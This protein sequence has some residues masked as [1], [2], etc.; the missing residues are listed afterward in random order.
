MREPAEIED[1]TAAG[2]RTALRRA[3]MRYRALQRV[4]Q[5]IWQMRDPD[6]IDQ[7]WQAIVDSLRELEIPFDHC[8]I[9]V[10]REPGTESAA[11][12]R[13]RT[14]AGLGI[15]E[16]FWHAGD[17]V[18]RHNLE[19]KDVYQERTRIEEQFGRTVRAVIDVPFSHGTL[20]LN[21]ARIDPFSPWH[22]EV[23]EDFTRALSGGFRRIEDLVQLEERNRELEREVSEG[24][25]Q[26]KRQQALHRVR[27]QVWRMR[28]SEEIADV[29]EKVGDGLR[30]MEV[31]FVFCGVNVVDTG[32]QHRASVYSMNKVGEWTQRKT[33]GT[34]SIL[35]IW[36]AG[37]IAYRRDI[38]QNDPYGERAR[39]HT[40]RSLLDV[41]FS[42]GTLAISSRCPGAFSD[43]DVAILQELAAALSE[44]FRRMDDLGTL[45]ERNRTLEQEVAEKERREQLQTARYRVREQVW[46]MRRTEDIAAVLEAVRENF[47]I[48]GVTY[49]YCSISL[50]QEE[51][52]E[53]QVVVYTLKKEGEWKR[54]Q[55]PFSEELPFIQIWRQNRLVYR[56]DI[57][58]D[59]PYDEGPTFKIP[60]RALVDVPFTQG[61]LALSS[62]E[63]DVFSHGDLE[64]LQVTAQLLAE[65][66]QRMGDLEVLEERNRDLEQEVTERRQTEQE[67]V[68]AKEE[69]E[70]ANRTKSTFLAHMS[71]E[72]R[73]P[74]NAILGFAQLLQRSP[75]LSPQQLENLQTISRSGEHLLAL[76]N[77]VLEMSRIEA[78][79]TLLEEEV[80]DLHALL[81]GL[82]EMFGLRAR[83]KGLQ[84]LCERGEDLPRY[85]RADEGKLRQILI[86][87]LSNAIK[88]TAGGGVVIRVKQAADRLHFEVEDTGLGI[89]PEEQKTLFDA[90][91]QTDTGKHMQAG[92]GLGLAITQQFV[93]LMGGEIEVKSAVGKGS[94]FRFDLP[95]CPAS[96]EELPHS[97]QTRRAVALEPGQPEYRILVVEDQE[98]NRQLMRQL[99]EPM[100][101]AFKEATDGRQGVDL[102][103]KWK[104]HLIWM[105]MRMPV[106]D[107]YE[108]T[109]Q[110]KAT[111]QGEKTK[112][113]ALTASAFEED[114]QKVLEAGC[115]DF[116]RKPFR[117]EEIFA[118]LE[119]HLGIRFLYEDEEE[120]S[121]T[122]ETLTSD[123]L[124]ELSQELVTE[125]YRVASQADDEGL[126]RLLEQIEIE[127]ENIARCLAEL[128]RNFRFDEIMALAARGSE[129]IEAS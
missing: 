51:L 58:R 9:N 75:G 99:L 24:E 50:V 45:E 83:D 108:A 95:A 43:E 72:L 127:H 79:R 78:G 97:R 54:Y 21:S 16:N 110:I 115:D 3:E 86:N 104:P 15:V 93:R 28:R 116:V 62:L 34:S 47:Q 71:H 14:D 8:G 121:G 7:V 85:V 117:A 17:T 10:V 66:F 76:I 96:V 6:D 81:D 39:F 73:T 122:E 13:A 42:H 98:E 46:K 35:S 101:F 40:I 63:P 119:H 56:P 67:L 77:D 33:V 92:T 22:I 37:K 49:D 74:L 88:F 126:H 118:M 2:G 44:G 30:A 84:L 114:R 82:A 52:E 59:D 25:R 55:F 27:E 68:R 100:G 60:I 23:L 90:F 80:F 1:Q 19:E 32:G 12:G 102:W 128:A 107:G 11:D 26:G 113:L 38:H 69:A 48:L 129:E 64:V 103:A 91:V 111:L 109:R 41:P 105:D 120:V 57:E 18:Y 4:Q 31:P 89:A 106:M 124:T 125:L 94:T 70:T 123:V 65:G 29:L 36:Q 61:T 20:A 87:L 5:Q 53:P 112:V